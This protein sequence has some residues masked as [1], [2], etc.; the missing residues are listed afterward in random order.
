[1]V[2]VPTTPDGV[3][4][5][6]E[7]MTLTATLTGATASGTA[8]PPGITDSGN[9]A[10]VDINKPPVVGGGN[11]AV[12]EEGLAGGIKDSNGTSD[13]TDSPQA[14]GQLSI[15][16]DNNATYSITLVAP[17]NGALTSHGTPIVWALSDNG[18]TLTGRAGGTDA[19]VI[20]IDDNGAYNVKL[21]A[22]V[23]HPDTSREDTG[24]VGRRQGVGWR[25]SGGVQQHQHHDRGR[26][27]SGATERP[28]SVQ[29]TNI[30]DVYTGK[31]SF[32]GSQTST[33][34]MKMTFGNGAIEVTAK[35]FTSKSDLTLI[36]ANVN[37]SKTG[38]GV[39]SKD[40]PYHNIANEID[41]RVGPMAR[42]RPKN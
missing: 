2:T 31:V 21:L 19:I 41:Y 40:A 23:D 39:A 8:L 16:D 7:S 1:V 4:E 35:G 18:H 24:P 12:S 38:L 34:Q 27:A 26:L 9:A 22:P 37:Q 3:Y 17:A 42:A 28:V 25:Q 29:T 11:T 6:R 33:N 20:K 30:P 14:N 10:I 15:T 13:T 5:G 36:D 32:A